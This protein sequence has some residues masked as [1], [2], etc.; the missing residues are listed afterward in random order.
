MK[1]LKVGVYVCRCGGNISDYVDCDRLRSEASK[2]PGVAVAR[3]ETYL[4]SKPSQDTI[5]ED[6][7]RKGLNRVVV[8]CCTPRMHL[9]TFRS[10][11]ER[12]GLNPYL[13]EFVNV[14][15]HCAWVHGSNREAATRKALSLLRA[16]YE[17]CLELEPLEPIVEEC[18][19]AALV[20]GGGIA[21]MTCA[22]ELANKGYEVYLV[23]RKASIGGNMAKLTK[24]FPTL[25]CAQCIL[26]PK[27]AEVGRHPNIKLLTLA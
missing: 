6:V 2:W 18:S 15:E 19:R 11:M 16:G 21:G 8:A 24:V 14:R 25:D 1:D 9:A 23:E 13:L 10:V 7:V 4:C 26:T 22:L 3:V 20:V 5:V 27:M 12:A 17:K